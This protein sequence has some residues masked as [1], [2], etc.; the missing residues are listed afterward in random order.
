[1][2][3]FVTGLW[4]GLSVLWAKEGVKTVLTDVA[5]RKAK[6]AD[7]RYSL[8]DTGGLFLE[9]MPTG[10]KFWRLRYSE[11]GSRRKLTLGQYPAVSLS[12]ARAKRDELG[13]AKV[14]GIN[15]HE[16]LHPARKLTF[17][18]VALEW[19]GKHVEP[20]RTAGHA[21]TVRYRLEA[22]LFPTLGERPLDEIKAPELLSVL[23]PVE[24]SGRVET[25]RRI[26]QIFGQVAR[27]G[28]ATGACESDVSSALRGALAPKRPQHFSA[29]TR[30]EDIRRLLSSMIASGVARRA[31]RPV[32]QPLHPGTPRTPRRGAA[33]GVGRNRP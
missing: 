19:F 7:K 9:V 31:L 2:G 4:A 14:R 32:V 20:V 22:F 8:Y 29:I 15:P 17:S 12:E 26:K 11:D 5:I 28:I 1:M 23:R 24:E 21:Q 18:D 13:E 3:H 10:K 27:Y 16:A 6:P 30:P 33:G 25:A